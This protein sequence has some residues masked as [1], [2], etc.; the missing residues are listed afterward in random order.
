MLE[1]KSWTL[2]YLI[3]L[4]YIIDEDIK[5]LMMTL[6]SWSVHGVLSSWPVW[7]QPADRLTAVK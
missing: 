5:I 1:G 3:K 2:K 4:N 6:K 7:V